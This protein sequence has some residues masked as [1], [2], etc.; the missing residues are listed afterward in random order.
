MKLYLYILFLL[1]ITISCK[2]R[3]CGT[4]KQVDL[5]WVP[6]MFKDQ[7]ITFVNDT[8]TTNKLLFTINIYP[9]QESTLNY[10]YWSQSDNVCGEAI[11]IEYCC[12]SVTRIVF[13]IYNAYNQMGL[14]T[15]DGGGIAGYDYK[16][17]G[18]NGG[19]LYPT[20]TTRYH[21]YNNVYKYVDYKDTIWY[22]KNYGII[23]MYKYDLDK[24][25]ELKN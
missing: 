13:S 19:V 8:D 7:E 20:F 25:F 3:D 15:S 5:E 17:I 10:D 16:E 2:P 1:A 22:V 18:L 24:N 23:K 9:P 6:F 4:L 11:G 14:N 12:N 21:T